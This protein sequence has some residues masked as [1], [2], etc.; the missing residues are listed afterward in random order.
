MHMRMDME[1]HQ[2]AI[3]VEVGESE[4]MR[5]R[6]PAPHRA[7]AAASA[8][9]RFDAA[10]GVKIEHPIAVARVQIHLVCRPGIANDQIGL[11]ISV[12]I[13]T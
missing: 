4:G 9:G 1:A 3:T 12:E 7:N 10:G 6:V 11:A 5:E 13:C 8:T 2:L